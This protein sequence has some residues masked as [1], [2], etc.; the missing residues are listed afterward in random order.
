MD[1]EKSSNEAMYGGQ[2][3]FAVSVGKT[4]VKGKKHSL[5]KD[6]KTYLFSNPVAKLLFRILPNRIEKA[7]KI[8][9]EHKNQ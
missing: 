8:W 9:N 6:G 5:V 1:E 3:A 2:C 4:H 7:D